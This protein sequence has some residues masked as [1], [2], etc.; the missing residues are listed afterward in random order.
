MCV[1]GGGVGG[2]GVGEEICLSIKLKQQS[3]L[4]KTQPCVCADS[5]RISSHQHTL[6]HS[7]TSSPSSSPSSS[8]P[9]Y[10]NLLPTKLGTTTGF[11]SRGRDPAHTAGGQLLI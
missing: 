1:N 10:Y 6:T 4:R 11:V 8:F 2:G 5:E 9:A 3:K 7:I